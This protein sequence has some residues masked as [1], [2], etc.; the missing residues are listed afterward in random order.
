MLSRKRVEVLIITVLACML[1]ARGIY[2]LVQDSYWISPK[3]SPA[4]HVTGVG[5]TFWAVAYFG[6]AAMIVGAWLFTK[7]ERRRIGAVLAIGGLITALAAFS[8]CIYIGR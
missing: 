7:A 8:M 4:I 6:L 2:A 3:Y 1:I 5:A